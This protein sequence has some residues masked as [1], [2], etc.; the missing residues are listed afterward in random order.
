ML[1]KLRAIFGVLKLCSGDR[2]TKDFYINIILRDV[3]FNSTQGSEVIKRFSCS[4]QLRL[5]FILG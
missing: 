3:L 2:Y 1:M 4:A 5:K